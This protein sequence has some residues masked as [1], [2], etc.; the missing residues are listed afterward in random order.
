[1]SAAARI[2][3]DYTSAIEPGALA[4]VAV[5]APSGAKRPFGDP[6]PRAAYTTA[7]REALAH[8]P[9]PVLGLV[10]PYGYSPAFTAAAG[11]RSDLAREEI[12]P[13]RVRVLNVGRSFLG[14]GALTAS[15]A[16]AALPPEEATRWL[17]GAS[18]A[19]GMWLIA[20][21]ERLRAATPEAFVEAPEGLPETPY[22]LLRVRLAARVLGGCETPPEG[23][24]TALATLAGGAGVGLVAN[25][26]DGLAAWRRA[27]PADV[28]W[29]ACELPTF[30]AAHFGDALAFAVT[31]RAGS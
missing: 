29:R 16:A 13:D 7:F 4:G 9:E 3:V 8:G 18:V 17:D 20:E 30:L 6:A 28:E 5:I 19:T 10:G 15:L 1:M 25:A 26:H 11:G 24:R 12:E 21:S 31:P 22:A 23:A 27:A 2:V 14:L